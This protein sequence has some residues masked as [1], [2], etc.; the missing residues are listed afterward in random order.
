MNKVVLFTAFLLM[1]GLAFGQ[2]LEKGTVIGAYPLEITL[3]PDVT[4]NQFIEFM[5]TKSIPAWEEHFEG[6][7]VFLLK[8]YTGDHAGGYGLIIFCESVEVYDMYWNNKGMITEKGQAI[9]DKLDPILE[10]QTKLG[11]LSWDFT[12]WVIL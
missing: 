9:M 7:H 3:N 12:D 4:M 1:G 6:T 5:Q 10:E 8:G 2:V 11:R